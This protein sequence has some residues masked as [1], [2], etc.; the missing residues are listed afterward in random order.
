VVIFAASERCGPEDEYAIAGILM[1]FQRA[2]HSGATMF[3][4]LTAINRAPVENTILILFYNNGTPPGLFHCKKAN[5]Y[6]YF[7]K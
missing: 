6:S 3:S 2:C 7:S 5:M 1:F 4:P